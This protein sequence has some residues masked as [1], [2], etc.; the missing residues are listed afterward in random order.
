MYNLY[1]KFGAI[2][3]ERQNNIISNFSNLFRQLLALITIK[4]MPTNNKKKKSDE[5]E[6][7]QSLLTYKL[8]FRTRNKNLSGI[9]E[10]C[11]ITVF[12]NNNDPYGWENTVNIFLM[13]DTYLKKNT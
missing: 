7:R 13:L 8:K 6:K 1:I 4:I 10:E 9:D 5:V 2:N 3:R 12:S 11:L